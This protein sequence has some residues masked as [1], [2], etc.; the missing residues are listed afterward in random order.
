MPKAITKKAIENTVNNTAAA[1]DATLQRAVAEKLK[2]AVATGSTYLKK[3]K[4][5]QA[6]IAELEKGELQYD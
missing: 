3:V 2:E 1:V 4:N 6:I 5:I